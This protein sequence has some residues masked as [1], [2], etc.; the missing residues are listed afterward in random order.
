MLEP[1]LATVINQA[2]RSTGL[3]R[4]TQLTCWLVLSG[5]QVSIVGPALI[6]KPPCRLRPPHKV[7]LKAPSQPVEQRA[8]H[9]G[10]NIVCHQPP[11]LAQA[12]PGLSRSSKWR[13]SR[14][15]AK[16]AWKCHF[17]CCTLVGA[18]VMLSMISNISRLSY[19]YAGKGGTLQEFRE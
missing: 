9:L 10:S 16:L 11:G 12:Q 1:K 14:E 18:G 5:V 15:P 2:M 17:E 4:F 8:L 6:M 3:Y 7:Q 19:A 13:W